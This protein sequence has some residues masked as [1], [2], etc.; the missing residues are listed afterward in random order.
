MANK[1]IIFGV[2]VNRSFT[3]LA[4][5]NAGI[6]NLG[7]KIKDLDVIRN[8]AGD[9]AVSRTDI[10]SLAGLDLP[11]QR[12][13]RKLTADTQQYK[14]IIDVT[15]GTKEILQGNLTVNGVLAASS[16]KYNYVEN[17]TNTIKSADISTSR[18]SSWSSPDTNPT[19]TSPIFY[20]GTV[21]VGGTITANSIKILS[22]AQ[23][24]RFPNSEVPTHKIQAVINGQTVYLYAMKGIPLIFEGFFRNYDTTVELLTSGAVSYRIV[25]VNNPVYTREF[26]NVGGTSTTS[27]TLI[28]RETAAKRRDVEI[29]HNPNNIKTLN[30]SN[31][32]LEKLPAAELPGLQSLNL[33]RNSIRTF[34][35]LKTFCP[36][37]RSLDI[38]ENNF[39]LTDNATLRRFDNNVL[40]RIPTTITSLYIGNTFNGSITADI[41]NT[42]TS[43][44]TFNIDSYTGGGARR[45]F[46]ADEYD[47]LGKLPEVPDTVTSYVA[48]YNAFRTIPDSIKKL[49]ALQT[50]SAYGNSITE[51]NMYFDSPALTYVNTGNIG[52]INIADCTNKSA[53][54]E[55][56]SHYTGP[57]GA[58][59]AALVTPGGNYKF[60]NCANL[61]LFY[62]Y[63]SS[64]N[65][66]IP[67][68]RGNPNLYYIE[69]QYTNIQGGRSSTEQEYVLYPDIFDDC[70]KSLRYFQVISSSLIAAPISPNVFAKTTGMLGI[71][72]CSYGR[73]VTGSIPDLSTMTD[74]RYFQMFQNRLTGN[75]PTFLNNPRLYYV[76]LYSN[77]LS[78]T[79]PNIVSS[80]LNYLYLHYNQLTGFVG[81]TTPNLYQLYISVNQITGKI[82]DMSNLT[83][84]QYFFMNNNLFDDY[85]VGS[86]AGLTSIRSIDLSNNPNLT[87]TNVN[88]I[89][90]DLY[91]NYQALPRS[92]V[93]VNIRNTDIPSGLAVEQIDYLR[94]KGWNIRT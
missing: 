59:S 70:A 57:T 2:N 65:G 7:L 76:H 11:V 52:R 75:V 44:V 62:I 67:K 84:L 86:F 29:Y 77:Q 41:K 18:V 26:P 9:G 15:A 90:N 58:D 64:Y 92:G 91:E 25:D 22:P 54:T 14:G 89:I 5:V 13:L 51:P 61:R 43:L 79:I 85:T 23:A 8:I 32:G 48:N 37:L 27:S 42:L 16:I 20:G 38:R 63:A 36:N 17:G 71:V 28:F 55:Y 10:K 4:D 30:V 19:N 31:I 21:E 47:T 72:F 74:L 39:T 68:F 66:P 45:Y 53:L 81:L 78:G 46:Y 1:N 83:R 50:F 73:G 6:E 24:V 60:Q 40:S 56:Y 94:T 80:S 93:Q 35:D 34:P 49:P 87:Q 3:D 12:Y 88:D 82:P 69:M 33:F